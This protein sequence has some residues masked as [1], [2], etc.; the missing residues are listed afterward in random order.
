M[1]V[2]TTDKTQMATEAH[3]MIRKNA[4]KKPREHGLYPGREVGCD[5]LPACMGIGSCGYWKT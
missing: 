4:H 2:I 3:G 1:R 5:D